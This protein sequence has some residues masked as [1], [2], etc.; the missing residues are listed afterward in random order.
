M[1]KGFSTAQGWASQPLCCSRVNCRIP[2]CACALPI[3]FFLMSL[4]PVFLC[5]HTAGSFMII[6]HRGMVAPDGPILL[7]GV[8][9]GS[10][11]GNALER[12]TSVVLLNVLTPHMALP[13]A[14]AWMPSACSIPALCGL[15]LIPAHL[16][17]FVSP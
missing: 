12:S 9:R 2:F 3:C 6:T 14:G 1:G 11:P 15:S 17:R 13:C 10:V 16:K 4:L 8:A 7:A 5:E